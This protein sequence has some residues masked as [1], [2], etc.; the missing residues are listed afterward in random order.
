MPL[1]VA[2]ALTTDDFADVLF[3]DLEL[4]DRGVAILDLVDFDRGRLVDERSGDVLDQP[5]QVGLELFELFFVR[6]CQ[7]LCCVRRGRGGL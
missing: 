1:R 2:A 3:V 6:A 7:V 5:L 4:V